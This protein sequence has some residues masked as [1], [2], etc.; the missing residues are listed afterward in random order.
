MKVW[1]LD[2]FGIDRL[3]LVDRT[4]VSP[5]PGQ[6]L[7]EMSA[8]SLNYR[9][10]MVVK[11]AYNPRLRFPQ[12]PLSDGVGEIVAL[13]P[14]TSGWKVG[15]RAAAT[16]MPG[17]ID[18]RLSDAKAKTALGAGNPGVAAERIAVDADALVAIPD[19]LTDAEAASL[20]CAAVTAWHALVVSGGIQAGQTVL[21]LGAGGVSVFALQFA[22][23]HGARVVGTSSSADK[24]ARA[25]VLGLEHGINYRET[26]DWGDKVREWSGG[27][28]DH[29]VEVGGAG[30]LEQSLRAV[31]MG[32]HIGLIGVLSGNQG[33]VN[34]TSILMKGVRMQGIFVGS[35]SMFEDMNRAIA[36]SRMKPVVDRVFRFHDLPAA[37]AYL[38]SGQHFGKVC[39]DH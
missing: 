2:G 31:R 25:A 4:D 19:H 28:V 17:W 18:G 22:R 37:L 7:L 23:M 15:Q 12:V 13:G 24:L 27:G 29:V 33:A 36:A 39:L 20:P 35:R 6:A 3:R 10:A 16:F 8:W 14:G 1:E 30:T 38:E 34:P 32:G 26:P 11:G 9:D 21:I 5:G